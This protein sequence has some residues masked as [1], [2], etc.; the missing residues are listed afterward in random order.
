MGDEEAGAACRQLGF[1]GGTMAGGEVSDD[2]ATRFLLAY[3]DCPAGATN[4]NA[5]SYIKQTDYCA[6]GGGPS[7]AMPYIPPG[8]PAGIICT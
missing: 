6:G 4:L 5:C 8:A 7:A 3:L 2:P 1:A